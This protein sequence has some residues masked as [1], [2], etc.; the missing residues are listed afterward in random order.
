MQELVDGASAAGVEYLVCA[1]TPIGTLADINDSI[2]VLN[3]TDEACKKAGLNFVYHN[4]DKEFHAVEGQIPY[5][6]FLKQTNVKMELDLA[7]SIKGGKDPVEMF[8]Q[9]PGRF[10]LWHVKDL[11]AK[12]E[13][14]LPVGE[15]TIDYKRIFDAADSAGMK[16]YFVEHDMPKDALASITSSIQHLNKMLNKG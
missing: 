14:V 10:P 8:K 7:W 2:D 3:K 12:H 5:D 1:N 4:H 16:Y 15:G 9:H 6:L 11:D 13:T